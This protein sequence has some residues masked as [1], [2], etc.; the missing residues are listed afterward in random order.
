MTEPSAPQ[1]RKSLPPIQI[2][3]S[4]GEWADRYSILCIKFRHLSDAPS[5]Q[6][7]IGRMRQ[8]HDQLLALRQPDVMRAARTDA[9]FGY[10]YRAL[11][12]VNERLWD[13]E[14]RL[15]ECEQRQ[16]FRNGFIAMARQVYTL[17]DR[18]TELKNKINEMFGDPPEVKILPAYQTLSD[19]Q[20]ERDVTLEEAAAVSRQKDEP[21]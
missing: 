9:V 21:A 6:F 2:T 8:V 16:D 18:R 7:D 11:Y 19:S 13:V 12:A 3:I 5:P 4:P 17:N 15:R 1:P 10:A 20:G 14:D